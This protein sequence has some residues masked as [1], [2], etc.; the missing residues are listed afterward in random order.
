MH[1]DNN[2]TSSSRAPAYYAYHVRGKEGR[3][4]VETGIGSAWP[5]NGHKS[6][7]IQVET[8]PLDGKVRLRVPTKKKTCGRVPLAPVPRWRWSTAHFATPFEL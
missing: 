3:N 5:H 8:T 6:Y 7:N 2:P 4:A 1:E